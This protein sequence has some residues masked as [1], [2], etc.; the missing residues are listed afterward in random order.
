MQISEYRTTLAHVFK[1]LLVILSCMVGLIWLDQQ[2]INSYW[3][4][5]FHAKSPWDGVTSPSWT[6][7]DRLMKASLAAKE[8]F[9]E[10]L[11]SAP[12]GN[13]Q[14]SIP[15]DTA[16]P[17]PPRQPATR[18][19]APQEKSLPS[20]AVK[21]PATSIDSHSTNGAA[22][23]DMGAGHVIL[24]TGQAVLFIG[25]SMMEGVAPHVIKMLRERYSVEGIDL[26]KRSTGLTYPHFFNWPL[27]LSHE[28]EKKQNIGLLVVFLGSNDPWD[29][30]SGNSK[31]FLRFESPAWESA[32][33]GR[34]RSILN[35]A[36]EKQIPVIWISPPNVENK[37]LNHGIN[38][39]NGLFE[40]EVKAENE[41]SIR[42]NDIFGYQN[43]VYSPDMGQDK[44]K[45][46]IRTNDG[47]HFSLTGQK[48]IAER[49]FSKINVRP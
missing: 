49:I 7:G 17:V 16:V 14:Q 33:R 15:N 30:P 39:I 22:S 1:S 3:E 44:A 11:T 13:T 46:R 31:N 23:A 48:M 32:Y 34:I 2:S 4:L 25:D 43:S 19:I 37:K 45:V 47:V 24:K 18:P 21:A 6:F 10:S 36:R 20:A 27:I 5:H 29:M 9:A 38:Y 8:T 41:I 35:L 42:G 40:S 28:L 12:E 26:S